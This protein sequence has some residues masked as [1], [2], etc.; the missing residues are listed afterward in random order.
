MFGFFLRYGI[1]RSKYFYIYIKKR[2][3]R[4]KDVDSF[5]DGG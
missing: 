2:H 5:V 1:C 3:L 4:F